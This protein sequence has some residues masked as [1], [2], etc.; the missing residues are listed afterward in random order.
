M[1]KLGLL[2]LYLKLYDDSTP[3]LRLKLEPFYEKCAKKFEKLGAEVIRSPFCRIEPE[4]RDAAALFR[5]E[6][7]EVIVTLHMAYSPSLECI[8]ALGSAGL[9]IIVLDTT[10]AAEF[11]FLQD[12]EQIMYNHGIH[13]VMDM[14]NLLKRRGVPYT[15]CAGHWE[16]P[17]LFERAVGFAKSVRAAAAFRGLRVGRIGEPFAGMGDFS[18]TDA[19]LQRD[20]GIEVVSFDPDRDAGYFDIPADDVSREERADLEKYNLGAVQCPAYDET[21]KTCLGVRRWLDENRLDAF[22]FSFLDIK[23]GSCP[24]IPPF[25]EASKAMTRGLGYAGE[26][27]TLTAGLV[28]ALQKG[29]S[30][31]TFIEIFCPDWA[32]GRLFLSHMGEI[33]LALAD[34]DSIVCAE[35][36]FPYTDAPNPAAMFGRYRAGNAIFVNLAPLGQGYGLVLADVEVVAQGGDAFSGSVRGWIKPQIPVARFLEA[37]SAAGA[38][39]HSALVYGAK[40]EELV[41]FGRLMGF[42]VTVL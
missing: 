16:D 23:S 6:G 13:G 11:G 40:F 42:E 28:A 27:D 20:F 3:G 19:G 1:L 39:H 35:M 8:D 36:D 32:G 24:R 38:T 10:E 30:N 29:F 12:P 34:P 15:V 25:M 37:I 26:G 31:T 41:F 33:N 4:F 2:P 7:A 18:V 21:I 9:P 14:C 17:G 5:N 22:T